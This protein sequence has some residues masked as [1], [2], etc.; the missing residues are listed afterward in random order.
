MNQATSFCTRKERP[1]WRSQFEVM[2]I[3]SQH[4]YMMKDVSFILNDE[5][6]NDGGH[7]NQE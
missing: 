6:I 5:E 3:S 4:V 2:E 1:F 7:G